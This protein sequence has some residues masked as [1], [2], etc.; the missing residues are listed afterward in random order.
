MNKRIKKKIKTKRLAGAMSEIKPGTCYVLIS[1]RELAQFDIDFL[2]IGPE[3]CY[4]LIYPGVV[5][6]EELERAAVILKKYET[7]VQIKGA[8]RKV[9]KL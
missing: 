8:L 7:C 1:S 4:P 6:R 2:T 9:I 5:A 3:C